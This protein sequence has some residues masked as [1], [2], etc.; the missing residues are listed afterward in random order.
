MHAFK[1]CVCDFKGSDLLCESRHGRNF[2]LFI[3]MYFLYTY[4]SEVLRFDERG[5]TFPASMAGRFFEFQNAPFR[6]M[7][8]N[9]CAALR[10]REASPPDQH[11]DKV[12]SDK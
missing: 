8:P 7:V 11:D 9:E 5:I 1:V 3:Y 10:Q 2:I 4:V 6:C 12:V